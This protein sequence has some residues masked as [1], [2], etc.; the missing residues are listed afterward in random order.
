M[1]HDGRVPKK[2]SESAQRLRIDEAELRRNMDEQKATAKR[3]AKVARELRRAAI[4][5]R[6]KESGRP[7]G[8]A[9]VLDPVQPAK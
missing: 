6:E 4:E 7:I 3:M 1:W 8:K 5:M 9:N 2:E